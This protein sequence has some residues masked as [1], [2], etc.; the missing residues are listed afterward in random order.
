MSTSNKN[1]RGDANRQ[2]CVIIG[3]NTHQHWPLSF[4]TNVIV[5]SCEFL[6]DTKDKAKCSTWQFELSQF[7]EQRLSEWMKSGG[8]FVNFDENKSLSSKDAIHYFIIVVS[9]KY[10]RLLNL[11]NRDYLLERTE[12]CGYHFPDQ[13]CTINGERSF[14]KGVPLLM[15]NIW[16]VQKNTE[17]VDNKDFYY[18]KV[19]TVDKN[20]FTKGCNH[21]CE[22]GLYNSH[23]LQKD[24]FIIRPHGENTKQGNYDLVFDLL[25]EDPS[26]MTY[27]KV[28]LMEEDDL[29][30]VMKVF[31]PAVN[32]LSNKQ[33]ANCRRN[34]QATTSKDSFMFTFGH[35]GI[36]SHLKAGDKIVFNDGLSKQ[37]CTIKSFGKV[38][39]GAF[40]KYF[41]SEMRMLLDL[42]ESFEGKRYFGQ[43]ANTLE[44]SHNLQN[45]SH[46]DA[47]DA[48]YGFSLWLQKNP[49]QA[50]S[51]WFFLLPNA[52]IEGSHG[53]AIQL[54]HGTM[55]CWNGAE[56]KHCT[57]IPSPEPSDAYFGCFMGPKIKFCKGK[58]NNDL[59][60][61]DRMRLKGMEHLSNLLE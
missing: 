9:R 15:P 51:D 30:K 36:S 31:N 40:K 38:L 45:A 47:G 57:M 60:L 33:N 28:R 59:P 21:Y 48:G 41:P 54:S 61:L 3:I 20:K 46:Y 13:E 56:L 55:I 32:K 44:I 19:S 12:L 24:V 25:L 37:N 39:G 23:C 1:S 22:G 49:S 17:I 10:K 34:K 8:T 27:V 52:T 6:H 35:D 42:E 26:K 16:A 18:K 7:I 4:T 50:A 53:V 5:P 58:Q 14:V 2:N 11:H 29:T 43:F